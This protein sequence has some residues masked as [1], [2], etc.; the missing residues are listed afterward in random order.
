MFLEVLS[1]ALR[2]IVS[3]VLST[4]IKLFLIVGTHTSSSR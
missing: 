2:L 4:G 3:L 1:V